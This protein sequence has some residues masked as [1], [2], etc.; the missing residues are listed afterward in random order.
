MTISI[1]WIRQLKG[2]EELVFVS[3]SRLSGDGRLFDSCPKMLTL[4]RNDCAIAFK[5]YTGDAFPMMLQLGLAIDAYNPAKRGELKLSSLKEHAIQVFNSMAE[6][7][8]CAVKP[9][10]DVSPSAEF[11]FGGY[12]WFRKS[13][14]LWHIRYMPKI[15]TFAA[16]AVPWVGYREE[17][18]S[19]GWSYKKT[20]SEVQLIGR[21]GVIGDNAQVKLARKLLSEKIKAKASHGPFS[22]NMEP[23]EV[24]RD[25]LRSADSEST[26]GGAPQMIIVHQFMHA[27][28]VGVYW[29]K[30]KSGRVFI[31]GRP[32]LGY[33]NI[34]RYILDPDTFELESPYK[35]EIPP[36]INV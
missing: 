1:A 28:P 19:V 26:I 35:T 29:P 18:G 36:A 7:I 12:S 2:R 15:K 30:K 24:V 22:L 20:D 32:I 9:K 27:A 33:E 25:M 4:P 16:S 14:Q 13:F 31:Q 23:F 8:I 5:G 3:D 6:T 11:L 34:D 17:F 10:Q 21:I